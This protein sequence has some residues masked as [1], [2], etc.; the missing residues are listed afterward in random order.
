MADEFGNGRHM[1]SPGGGGKG[2]AHIY[3]KADYDPLD[4]V[5]E[6][7][8]YGVAPSRE[9]ER[10]GGVPVAAIVV[11]AVIVVLAAIAVLVTR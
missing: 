8:S 1:V 9:P 10:R 4:P 7:L 5:P 2:P 6:G 3:D 11:A